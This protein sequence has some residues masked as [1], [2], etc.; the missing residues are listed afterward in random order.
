MKAMQLTH[1]ASISSKP[2]RIVQIADPVPGPD[3]VLVRVRASA[4]CRTDLHVIEGELKHTR[5]PIIP[6]HQIAGIVESLGEKCKKIQVGGRVGVAWLWQTCGECS[7]CMSG[8]ENLCDSSQYTGC[9]VNGG[10]AELVVAKEDYVYCLPE[11]LSCSQA[12]P[13]LCAGIIGYRALKQSA[14]KPGGRL[15]I[16]GFGSSAHLAIQ[17]ARY[18]GCEVFVVSRGQNHLNLAKQLGASW[19]GSSAEELPALVDSAVVF[20]PVG[21]LVPP[22]LRALKKGGTCA[23]AGVCMSDVPAMS[24]DEHLFHEKRLVSVESNTRVDGEEFLKIAEHA[25]LC[26]SVEEFPL[27]QANEVLLSL[28]KGELNGTAVFTL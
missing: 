20:A 23:L 12:A 5:L 17:V 27:E 28:K 7:F 18:W 9:S 10:Y 8:Q 19:A 21:E 3:E 26:P 14:L 25:A 2:L 11:P 1:Y 22:A 4:V 16:F 13:L 6:G 24:Y 15:A